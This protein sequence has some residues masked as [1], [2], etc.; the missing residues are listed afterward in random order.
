MVVCSHPSLLHFILCMKNFANK[1]FRKK[2]RF[3]RTLH[4]HS[5]FFSS[6]PSLD[7]HIRLFIPFV[8]SLVWFGRTAEK[9]IPYIDRPF[10]IYIWFVRSPVTTVPLCI[11]CACP[12]D[13][14]QEHTRKKDCRENS[15][16]KK[17]AAA[18]AEIPCH[19]VCYIHLV[20][21]ILIY[22]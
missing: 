8:H 12:K 19:I 2:V 7:C 9:P 6:S 14:R 17:T 13:T 18:A 3:I 10:Y 5:L 21:F 20:W 4:S 1:T 16:E 22:D 15:R 11:R